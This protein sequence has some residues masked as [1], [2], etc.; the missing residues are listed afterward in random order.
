MRAEGAMLAFS[1]VKIYVF[2]KFGLGYKTP[3]QPQAPK[4]RPKKI[5]IRQIQILFLA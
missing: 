4:R 1:P 3:P 2:G 5:F